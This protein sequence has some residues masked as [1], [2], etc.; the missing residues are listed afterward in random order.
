MTPLDLPA[1][2][3]GC[4]NKKRSVIDLRHS[5]RNVAYEKRAFS[6]DRKTREYREEVTRLGKGTFSRGDCDP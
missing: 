5:G 4:L 6:G 1:H 2:R 3:G